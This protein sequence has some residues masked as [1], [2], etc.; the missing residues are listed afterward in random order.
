MQLD[1]HTYGDPIMREQARPVAV[2]DA[3]I[4]DLARDMIATMRAERGVGL[5]AQQVGRTEAICVLD[6]PPDYDKDDHGYPLHPDVE[7]PLVMVNPEIIEFSAETATADEGCLS[8]PE[9]TAAIT[10]ATEIAVRYQDLNGRP[11][12]RRFRRFLAR[13]IQHEVD[14][15]NGIL[16]VNRMSPL[17]KIAIAGQLK[18]LRRETEERL[19]RA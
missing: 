13:A 9:I 7:M 14:H 1:I 3:A 12:T 2:F 17:K 8:F 11:Q 5:A 18:R 4:H 16:L 6:I 15:L 19:A 10:R